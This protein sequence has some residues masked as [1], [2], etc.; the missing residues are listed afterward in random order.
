[1]AQGHPDGLAEQA[2]LGGLHLL[3]FTGGPDLHHRLTPVPAFPGSLH[4]FFHKGISSNKI[5]AHLIHPCA[6]FSE[7]PDSHTNTYNMRHPPKS[8]YWFIL[9]PTVYESPSSLHFCQHIGPQ[10]Q[11]EPPVSRWLLLPLP[12]QSSDASASLRL[13]CLLV[14]ENPTQTA[15]NTKKDFD[16][17]FELNSPE[18]S[19]FRLSL[20]QQLK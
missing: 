9:I 15:L 16:L 1:M 8:P 17:F 11:T 5:L 12:W 6:C 14:T 18:V 20:I 4:I 13:C 10:L 3:S 7:D 2:S 19:S